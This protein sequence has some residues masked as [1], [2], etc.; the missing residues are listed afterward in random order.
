M[1]TEPQPTIKPVGQPISLAETK[2]TN[3]RGEIVLTQGD[4]NQAIAEAD[5]DIKPF[6]D[7]AN[8]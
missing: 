2:P 3:D 4:V 8:R 5:K 6:I 7:A 1:T